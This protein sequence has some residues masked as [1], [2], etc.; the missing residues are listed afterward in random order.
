MQ[1]E[2]GAIERQSTRVVILVHPGD[3]ASEEAVGEAIRAFRARFRGAQV[4]RLSS[5]ATPAFF[6]D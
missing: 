3:A 4:M 5:A 6:A 2:N 1:H